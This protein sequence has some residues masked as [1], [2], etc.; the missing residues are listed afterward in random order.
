MMTLPIAS[1]QGMALT[2]KDKVITY[3]KLEG[4]VLLDNDKGITYLRLAMC[5]SSRQ[6]YGHYHS[7]PCNVDFP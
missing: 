5:V 1:L 3:P 6:G 7:K 4:V 2:D